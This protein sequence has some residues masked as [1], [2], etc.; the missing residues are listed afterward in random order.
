MAIAHKLGV[1]DVARH[2]TSEC[3][4]RY[5]RDR[6]VLLVL[7]NCEQ[8]LD[9]VPEAAALL[10]S[11]PD[12]KMMA[13]SRQTL[14][15]LGEHVYIVQPLRIPDWTVPAEPEA[16]GDFPSVELFMARATAADP[17]FALTATNAASVAEVCA[18]LDGLP[19]GLELAAAGARSLA[20]EMMLARL[21]SG[22]EQYEPR[23]A[24]ARQRSLHA[25]VGWSHDLLGDGE[26]AFFRQLAVF[27]GGWTCKQLRQFAAVAPMYWTAWCRSWTRA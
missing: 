19:L 10:A 12:V 14:H 11:C 16:L 18:R 7:D 22:V 3:L 23:D 13:T 17:E 2:S 4:Q 1:R 21:R 5:L 24:P 8:V 9:F 27:E 6:H 25:T 26:Q 15:A 20:P